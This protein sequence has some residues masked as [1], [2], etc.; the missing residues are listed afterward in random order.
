M[1]RR[2]VTRTMGRKRYKVILLPDEGGFGI[3]VPELPGCISQGDTEEEAL[4]NIKD[5]IQMWLAAQ[6]AGVDDE[7]DEH[8][9]WIRVVELTV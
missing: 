6:R 5:A 3:Y 1:S 8:R 2:E 4:D 7:L 9:E